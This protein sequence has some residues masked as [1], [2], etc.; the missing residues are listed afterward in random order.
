MQTLTDRVSRFTRLVDRWLDPAPS[1]LL[2][3]FLI[4]LGLVAIGILATALQSIVTLPLF[5]HPV[6]LRGRYDANEPALS[7]HLALVLVLSA[8]V[9]PVLETLAIVAV[10]YYL[11]RQWAGPRVFLAFVTILALGLHYYLSASSLTNIA[12]MFFVFGYQYDLWTR[13]RGGKLAFWGVALTHGF[14]NVLAYPAAVGLSALQQMV[15]GS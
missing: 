7:D 14:V 1:I 9:A 6:I 4:A 2:K 8:L 11:L 10:P 3:A 5:G 12:T 13:L 15:P